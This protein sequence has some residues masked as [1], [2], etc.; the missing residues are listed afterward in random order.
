[1][2]LPDSR[3]L[4]VDTAPAHDRSGTT[5]PGTA[6]VVVLGAG[7]AGL[8]AACRLAEA[9]RD[10]VVLEAG[11]VAAGVSG[12]TI[13]KVTAQHA[14]RYDRLVRNK[15][16]AGAAEYAAAQLEAL[17]WIERG[18][19]SGGVDCSFQR[20]STWIYST[21]PQD[22]EAYAKEAQACRRVG[23]AAT[24][25]TETPL[26]FPV[27]AAVRVDGQ[28]QFH[29]RR[30]LLH[31]AERV[32]AAGGSIVEQCRATRVDGSTVVTTRGVVTGRDVVVATH[33]PILD[34]AGFFARLEP[35]R[36]LVVSGPVDPARA[37]AGAFLCT[38]ESR[39]VRTVPRDDGS[40]DLIVG[41]EN[42]RVG[43]RTDVL[44][45]HRALAS[46]AQEWFGVTSVT[47][48]WSAHDLVTPDGMMYAGR[49]HPAADHL[50]VATGFNLWGMTGGTAAGLLVADLVEGRADQE[51]AALFNPSRADIDQV[52][53]LVKDNAVVARHLVGDL[54]SAATRQLEFEELAPGQSRV[55]RVGSRLVAA[56]R[57]DDGALHAVDARC[58]HLGCTVSFN[59]AERSWDCPCHG[60]R[61]ALDGSV[62]HGPAVE[63][64]APVDEAVATQP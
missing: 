35:I 24:L 15:D 31:L 14:L 51:R 21:R 50:W 53:G 55:G 45:R 61:Y 36:D 16:L 63:P 11:Q 40:T 57:A 8:T 42:Y 18:V 41:G 52:P 37:P 56:H 43:T 6:D 38:S 5:L 44:E 59:D 17:E 28:A 64:L 13:A 2:R 34:R 20:V 62:L 23:L 33:F 4:W 48:R 22:R 10:V 60:S 30:W 1:M 46:W 39:S 12:N 49:Y 25:L 7:I 54:A 29:P 3:S 19:G 58:T 9:G 32:E 26:P 47:H 27:A